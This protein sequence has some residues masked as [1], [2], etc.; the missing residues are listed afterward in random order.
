M[1][2]KQIRVARLKQFIEAEGGAAKVANKYNVNASYLSQIING[3]A[4]FAEKSA[5][6]L[7]ATFNLPAN[8]LDSLEVDYNKTEKL[9]HLHKVAQHLP[10]WAIDGVIKDVLK[11]V[12]L[13]ERAKSENNGTHNQ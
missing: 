2:L 10:E 6:K 11:T 1:E 12:E 3:H 8:S 4:S 9:K 13:I 7:E 5:R